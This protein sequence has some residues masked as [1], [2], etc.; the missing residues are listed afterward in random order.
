MSDTSPRPF[1]VV[2]SGHVVETLHHAV[3][4]A[5]AVDPK[6]QVIADARAIESA[7]KWFADEFGESRYPVGKMGL[8]RFGQIGRLTVW[9]AVNLERWEAT[10]SRFGFAPP[11]S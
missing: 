6:D 2:I 5:V 4:A 8:M 1:R 9:Y 11:R 10:V 7:L 3:R